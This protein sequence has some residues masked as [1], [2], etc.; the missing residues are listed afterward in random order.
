MTRS[1]AEE[2]LTAIVEALNLP[3]PVGKRVGLRGGDR[4]PSCFPVSDLA[5]ASVGAACATIAEL[6][7]EQ[8]GGGDVDVD[9]RLTSLWFGWSIRPI[10]WDMPSAWDAIAGDY[11]A[12]DGWIKLHT[13]APHHRA[14]ALSVLKCEAAREAVAKEVNRWK[15]EELETAIV[16][17]GGCAAQLRTMEDWNAHPQ[18]NSVAAEPLVIWDH[19]AQPAHSAWCPAIGRPLAGLKVLDLTRVLAG[20]VATRFL[21]GY[22]ADVLRIDPPTWD[23]PGVIPE[24]T[25][26]KRCARLDLKQSQDREIFVQLLKQADVLIHGY[27]GDALD[28]LG[29]GFEARQVIRPGLIDISLNAYGHSGPWKARRGFDSLVQF[30]SGIAAAGMDWKASDI[31]VSLPVQALDHATGYLIA[32]AAVRGLIARRDGEGSIRAQLSLARTAK[33]LADHKGKSN[34]GQ[35][36]PA[37]DADYADAVEQTTWGAAQRLH[38]PARIGSL[39]MVWDRPATALGSSLASWK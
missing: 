36:D 11:R 37:R 10:G 39:P 34:D 21:A 28:R 6:S 4:L 16:A 17:A 14:A 22:G 5:V 27:R 2:M 18:G 35:F 24:V 1:T 26:G 9:Y 15:T 23:E 33:F 29:L 30:S 31:P 32:A 8:G 38:S 25:L 3:A 13:N 12:A 20:P 7:S 19:Q